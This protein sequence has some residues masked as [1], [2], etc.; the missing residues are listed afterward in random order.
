MGGNK[1]ERESGE[2]RR[3]VALEGWGGGGE[4]RERGREGKGEEE[5]RIAG[6]TRVNRPVDRI[7][8]AQDESHTRMLFHQFT[9]HVT[10]SRLSNS[11]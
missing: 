2:G 1:G 10:K 11:L 5:D 8:S 6:R 9:T 3:Y 7:G 4:G